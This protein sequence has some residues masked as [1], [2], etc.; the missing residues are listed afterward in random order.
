MP[1]TVPRLLI[2]TDLDRTLLPNGL[3]TESPGAL[4]ALRRLVSRPEVSLAYV[5]GRRL[6]LHLEAMR[7]YDV[8]EP[9][10]IIADVGAS[11][12]QNDGG[13][14]KRDE[15]WF[16]KLS[17]AWQG[18]EWQNVLP[19][20]SDIDGLVLQPEEAQAPHKLSF[21]VGNISDHSR[22]LAEVE[23]RL[24]ANGIRSHLIWSVDET[25]G[26]GLLDVMAEGATK[27]H[28]VEWLIACTRTPED[29]V[30]Y[31]GDSG[32][33]LPVLTS[34]VRSVLVANATNEV[35]M[36]AIAGSAPHAES[37]HL[38]SGGALGMNGCYSAGILEGVL[39]YF[40]EME[41]WMKDTPAD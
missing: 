27:L 23:T 13:T 41:E 32:N 38:A 8:P 14:W 40:P 4:P 18:R 29:R 35:R 17:D 34:G 24:S 26:M 9:D 5:S 6:E 11:I 3:Q 33:D 7:T 10:Y 39:H 16:A 19:L 37:L 2:C 12:Y 15:R 31:A 21:N 20:L 22:I 36:E 30:L 25:V 1:S 28:A